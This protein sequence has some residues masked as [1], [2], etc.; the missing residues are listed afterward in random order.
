MQKISLHFNLAFS[1]CSSIYQA[2]VEQTEFLW[3]FNFAILPYSKTVCFTVHNILRLYVD[4][5]VN[6]MYDQTLQ[7]LPVL[8]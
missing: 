7:P 8:V 6:S 3:V 1:Q 4:T 2:F 5:G